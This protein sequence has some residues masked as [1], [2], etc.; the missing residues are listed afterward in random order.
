MHSFRSC[1]LTAVLV[2]VSTLTAAPILASPP[3]DRQPGENKFPGPEFT[4]RPR[5]Y[6]FSGRE[7]IL[8]RIHQSFQANGL[9]AATTRPV[10][11]HGTSGVG[12]TEIALEYTHR[13]YEKYES[14]FWIDATSEETAIDSMLRCQEA[15]LFLCRRPELMATYACQDIIHTIGMNSQ[16][17]EQGRD[18]AVVSFIHWLVSGAS[19]PW[20]LVLD[21]LS[22][23]ESDAPG[24]P[25]S[26]LHVLSRLSG[27]NTIITTRESATSL[28]SHVEWEIVEVGKMGEEEALDLLRSTSGVSLDLVTTLASA[29]RL[30]EVL[31]YLPL[32]V[33]LAGSYIARHPP[34]EPILVR[35]HRMQ[36]RNPRLSRHY[37]QMP[38]PITAYLRLFRC[39]NGSEP[40]LTPHGDGSVMMDGVA[41][42]LNA[43]YHALKTTDRVALEIID[44][45]GRF[46]AS[47]GIWQELFMAE[48]SDDDLR[49]GMKRAVH[50]AFE[51]LV[52]YSILVKSSHGKYTMHPLIQ[53]W[54]RLKLSL[55]QHRERTER[56]ARI[57]K[58]FVMRSPSLVVRRNIL[59]YHI[60]GLFEIYKE[61]YPCV[62]GTP[63]EFQ[64]LFHQAMRDPTIERNWDLDDDRVDRLWATFLGLLVEGVPRHQ[65]VEL[66]EWSLCQAFKT[67]PTS[68]QMILTAAN[69]YAI[70]LHS[71][72]VHTGGNGSTAWFERNLPARLSVLGQ[73]ASKSP[74]MN[75]EMV[76]LGVSI[77]S[78][79]T[80]ASCINGLEQISLAY[81]LIFT[82][83]PDT[84]DLPMHCTECVLQGL[85]AA[86]STCLPLGREASRPGM[87]TFNRF[88]PRTCDVR[89]TFDA[90]IQQPGI[91]PLVRRWIGVYRANDRYCMTLI[92]HYY[93]DDNIPT[94]A[95]NA[96]AA[97]RQPHTSGGGV[98][99]A[100]RTVEFPV[101]YGTM[102]D[103]HF[104]WLDVARA[105][106]MRWKG[107]TVSL[108][109]GD[110]CST[111]RVNAQ[112]CL[113]HDL[114]HREETEEPGPRGPRFMPSPW[115]WNDPGHE[116]D[117]N[118]DQRTHNI[119]PQ[120]QASFPV[121]S[122]SRPCAK[123]K[124]LEVNDRLDEWFR[125]RSLLGTQDPKTC[126]QRAPVN[127]AME[128]VEWKSP[129]EHV[130][131]TVRTVA[132]GLRLMHWEFYNS[133][134]GVFPL[135]QFRGENQDLFFAAFLPLW[136]DAVGYARAVDTHLI[137]SGYTIDELGENAS[138]AGYL[139]EMWDYSNCPTK[140][141]F[142]PAMQA[143]FEN[144]VEMMTRSQ[145]CFQ[146]TDPR[147]WSMCPL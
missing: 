147:S 131:E 91:E 93:Y 68:K 47:S 45:T 83:K 100:S 31:D 17:Y 105:H 44:F 43:T 56:A 111:L 115:K 73:D 118:S 57:L 121:I 143:V 3:T 67:R 78:S 61:L 103:T 58:F 144:L 40:K 41:A 63:I 112:I 117:P 122:W 98:F 114:L 126:C 130:A 72:G 32:A 53:R 140:R 87:N 30:I 99:S 26:I 60:M 24:W 94:A 55:D 119:P 52:S 134:G 13:F 18:L 6:L 42:A 133:Y 141:Q 77:A 116:Q 82:H 110:G 27:G 65:A 74:E 12:K 80:T 54:S 46:G 76:R 89:P 23:S 92:L 109:E 50:G 71:A 108:F 51:L 95:L 11:L 14:V 28:F 81:N 124:G 139:L 64:F 132:E 85:S 2:T 33:S 97:A 107:R 127:F 90:I 37:W 29:R 15:T 104:S 138:M 125:S 145:F 34:P 136:L 35:I 9:P 69:I 101:T 113:W 62:P 19:P 48:Y 123:F 86:L 96:F 5:N 39:K 22:L 66:T 25:S 129:W 84:D 88:I 142:R 146:H 79:A 120:A 128:V 21:N 49:A 75:E 16:K 7:G 10:V 102:D 59:K 1:W 137:L 4:I 38:D 36:G 106:R 135:S 8:H 70:A 20:L